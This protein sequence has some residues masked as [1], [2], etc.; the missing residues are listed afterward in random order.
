[1]LPESGF[2]R[3][4]W[5]SVLVAGIAGTFRAATLLLSWRGALVAGLSTGI[6]GLASVGSVSMGL[7]SGTQV[8]LTAMAVL[9]GTGLWLLVRQWR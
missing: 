5:L 3:G 6:S 2:A 9:T 1:M 8:V 7:V 4:V